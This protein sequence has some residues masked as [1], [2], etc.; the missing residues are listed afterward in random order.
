MPKFKLPSTLS[1]LYALATAAAAWE[2]YT[3]VNR[4]PGD[5]FSATVRKLGRAQPFIVL[6]FGLICGHLWWPL[7]DGED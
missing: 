4:E 2:I 6:G 3:I 5:T 1:V 7:L